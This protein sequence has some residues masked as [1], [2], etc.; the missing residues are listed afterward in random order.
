MSLQG[1]HNLIERN[2]KN[3]NVAIITWGD[4]GRVL[5]ELLDRNGY[6]IICIIEDNSKKWGMEYNN[7]PIVSSGKGAVMFEEGSVEKF[8]SPSLDEKLNDRVAKM[9]VAYGIGLDNLLY[10]PVETLKDVFSDKERIEKICLYTERTELET[11]EVHVAEHCNLNCK[12]CSM[13]CGLVENVEFPNYLEFEIGI[14]K[15][16]FFFPHIKK[17]RIIGG[18]PL[19]NPELEKYIILIRK[20]Y[21]Y[22]DIRLI[23][24]GILV[25]KMSNSLV[26]TIIEN[27][28]TFIVTQYISLKN[29]IDEI[30]F[31]LSKTGINYIITQAV[32]EFQK[33][34]N[35]VG[36]SDI[37]E[38]F[39]H[40]HWKGG[41]ATIYG[42][43][44]ATCY[45]PFVIHYLSD[46]F[47]LSIEES[48]KID[49]MEEGITS[50]EIVRR[51]NTPFDMCRYCATN[52]VWTEWEQ[53]KNKNNTTIQDWSM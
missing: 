4:E 40:C 53:L 8:I 51:M 47:N 21:P 9:L 17:F 12:N 11:M 24:N 52:C 25:T 14:T 49:L 7:T 30:K 2:I 39:N 3:M 36:D 18:E 41:C 27:K 33:I 37:E 6:N 38:S 29:S 35:A 23:S 32:L 20:I 50:Q 16:K 31:F 1:R 34:Y 45:V 48:G 13:F 46:R 44:V 28:V 22:T 42:S 26:N 5:Y 19:L 43:I 10:A 15:L